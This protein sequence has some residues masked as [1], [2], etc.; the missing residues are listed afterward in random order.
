MDLTDDADVRSVVDTLL[1]E[2]SRV[3]VLVNNAARS[4]R[5]PI[6]ESV[7]RLHDYERTMAVNYLGA[8]RLTLGQ[9]IGQ[10]RGHRAKPRQRQPVRQRNACAG[11]QR[12]DLEIAQLVL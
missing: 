5:R 6:R 10:Q 1:A 12:L 9:G 11:P 3:D 8:V 2:H 7:D 4:I